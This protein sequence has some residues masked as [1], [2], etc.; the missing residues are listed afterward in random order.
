MV[1]RYRI[2]N[3]SEYQPRVSGLG[4][5]SDALPNSVILLRARTGL[6]CSQSA[7]QFAHHVQSTARLRRAVPVDAA[8]I[9]GVVVEQPIHGRADD[10]VG[11]RNGDREL[12]MKHATRAAIRIEYY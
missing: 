4:A 9:L 2:D 8:Q 7:Y 12:P 1:A 11:P 6:L 5:P 10:R 3:S